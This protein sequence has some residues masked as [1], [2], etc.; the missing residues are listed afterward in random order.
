MYGPARY[1]LS[2]KALSNFSSAWRITSVHDIEH[3]PSQSLVL[4]ET[5]ILHLCEA[6][7]VLTCPL[8]HKVHRGH[9]V[10][11]ESTQD[12]ME[13]D[14]REVEEG[15]AV[16]ACYLLTIVIIVGQL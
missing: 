15:R 9:F 4:I 11:S 14:P 7:D 12:T 8:C 6:S 13:V 2:L 3:K 5:L 16:S 1:I 10:R